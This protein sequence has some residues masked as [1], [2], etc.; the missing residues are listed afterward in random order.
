MTCFLKQSIYSTQIK[1]HIYF[2]LTVEVK[3]HN[4]CTGWSLRG[5]SCY[6]FYDVPLEYH[7]ATEAC[8]G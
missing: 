3:L 8:Q 7:Q 1:L 4:L 5:T 6:K 2:N